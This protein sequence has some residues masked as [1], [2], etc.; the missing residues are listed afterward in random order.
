MAQRVKNPP[1]M[2][3]TLVRSL[4]SENPLEKGRATPFS[5][6]LENPMDR[7]AWWATVHRVAKSRTQL[8]D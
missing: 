4:G 3:E 6:L 5:V 8:S 7:R 1:A 2:Q